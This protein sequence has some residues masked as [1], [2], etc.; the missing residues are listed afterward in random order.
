[1]K[2][3]YYSSNAFMDFFP[4]N[5]RS[6]FNSYIDIHHLDYLQDENIEAAIKSI[7]YD[8]KT[9]VSIKK[10]YIKPNLVI[11]EVISEA[12]Y[13]DVLDRYFLNDSVSEYDLQIF[14][15]SKSVDYMVQTDGARILGVYEEKKTD[16]FFSNIIILFPTFIIH[17]L[18]LHDIDIESENQLINYMNIILKKVFNSKIRLGYIEKN[19]LQ[20][21]KANN[22]ILSSVEHDVYFSSELANLLNLGSLN[23]KKYYSERFRDVF[24]LTQLK[25]LILSSNHIFLDS[26]F[27]SKQEIE[28]YI[29]RKRMKKKKLIL[30]LFKDDRLYGIR[31]NITDPSLFNSNYNNIVSLFV[32]NRTDDTVHIDF[33]NPS[34]FTTRK[35]LLSRAFFQIIEVGSGATPKFATGTP[36]YIQVVV[37]KKKMRKKF[38]IF[39]DSSCKK[40]KETHPENHPTNFR[41][42]LPERLCFSKHWQVSLKSLFLPNTI[43]NIS[44][45]WMI[46]NQVTKGDGK[47]YTN[48]YESLHSIRLQLKDGKYSTIEN[49]LNI[50][51]ENILKEELPLEITL[52]GERI[53]IKC[54]TWLQ[55]E[56]F[57]EITM[58]D[59]LASI[60]GY[61]VPT[62]KFTKIILQEYEESI[63]LYEPNIFVMYPKNIVIGCDILDETI[64]GGEHVKLLKMVTNIKHSTR[65]L[66]N[67]E[68]LQDEFIDLNVKQFKNI[69]INI[70]DA[71]GN[72]V[73]TDNSTPTTLQL[74]FSSV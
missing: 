35:E 4:T 9:I 7:T 25:N 8:D 48:G 10:N 18:F 31:S 36:T 28:Y 30:N 29:V 66:L 60:L 33:K 63:S 58:S 11:K 61:I 57:L 16:S 3:I 22:F 44:N 27:N 69:Q 55:P 74:E 54:N 5:S 47:I 71:T 26:L 41:I 51:S 1:M 49:V 52:D 12:I 46:C 14:D 32:G 15:L 56:T 39:L 20:R 19:I 67:F 73:K 72:L 2:N 34:F 23:L 68:F 42:E 59:E 50:L 70:M 40:S 38:N 45:C 43:Y 17:N 65:N 6:N 62:T 53:K 24:P 13:Y 21:G 64:F 37:R